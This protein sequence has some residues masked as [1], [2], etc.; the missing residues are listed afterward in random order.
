MAPYVPATLGRLA[1]YHDDTS[2][3]TFTDLG[4]AG[5]SAS[6]KVKVTSSNAYSLLK[7]DSI[8]VRTGSASPYTYTF[9]GNVLRLK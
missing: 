2:D 4:T 7:G 9:I 6:S 3:Y 8:F 5:S 1:E